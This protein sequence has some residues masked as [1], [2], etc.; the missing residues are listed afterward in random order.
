MILRFEAV[1]T[2]EFATKTDEIRYAP[3]EAHNLIKKIS[4][5]IF[6]IT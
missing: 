3:I 4:L 5:T 6:E 1:P 2:L